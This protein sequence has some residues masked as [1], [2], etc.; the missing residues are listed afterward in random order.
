MAMLT[1]AV[2][3]VWNDVVPDVEADFNDWYVRDHLPDRVSLPGFQR[4]RRW[5]SDGGSPRYFTFYEIDDVSVMSSPVYL[6]RHENPTAWTRKIMPTFV[7]MNR[8]VCRVTAKA[9]TADGGM[10]GVIRLSP[11]ADAGD[12]LRQYLSREIL[13]RFLETPGI[14]A[15]CLWELDAEESRMPVTAE[16]KL[17]ATTDAV[18]DWALVVEG[19]RA[20]ELAM[21]A[22]VIE[23]DAAR[24]AGAASQTPLECYR[25]LGSL[26]HDL[27]RPG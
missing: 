2:M 13:P 25:L 15:A 11:T 23:P 7:G 17:R 5:I 6:D 14:V 20:E 18:I 26:R 3:A 16:T 19:G 4:G 21:A 10:A 27:A 12:G 8:S 1:D 24:A 9:G 22:G